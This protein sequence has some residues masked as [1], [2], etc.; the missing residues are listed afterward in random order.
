ME[1]HQTSNGT[2]VIGSS[3][4]SEANST[5]SPS[6]SDHSDGQSSDRD[7]LPTATNSK[8]KVAKV[9]QL[10]SKSA[11]KKQKKPKCSWLLL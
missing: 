3:S 10:I 1:R 7:N 11:A 5:S 6:S 8:S 9:H 4:D 2:E